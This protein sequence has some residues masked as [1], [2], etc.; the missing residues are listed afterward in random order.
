MTDAKYWGLC[1]PAR[2]GLVYL[3]KETE[4]SDPN[5]LQWGALGLSITWMFDL[6]P[7][8]ETGYFGGPM[9]WRGPVHKMHAAMLGAYAL[10][11]DWRI[12]AADTAL[13]AV[14]YLTLKPK[15]SR[16]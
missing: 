10:K 16:L 9:W 13:G 12:L 14:S 1:F 2:L 7:N 5:W 8:K 6:Q 11:D 15:N 4:G 3:A